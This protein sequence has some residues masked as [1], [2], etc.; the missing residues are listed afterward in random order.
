MPPRHGWV[1]AAGSPTEP[2]RQTG[3]NACGRLFPADQARR[4][5]ASGQPKGHAP[6]TSPPVKNRAEHAG[7][8]A[9][10]VW[11][12]ARVR[13]TRR[14]AAAGRPPPLAEHDPDRTRCPNTS[15]PP[16]QTV[17]TTPPLRTGRL[18]AGRPRPAVG[19]GRQCRWPGRPTGLRPGWHSES[20]RA[21]ECPRL[22]K[23]GWKHGISGTRWIDSKPDGWHPCS[24]G[25]RLIRVIGRSLTACAAVD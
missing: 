6:Q 11:R 21:S 17:R 2:P 12:V 19:S 4:R 18:P 8:G 9:L 16:P 7:A 24:K 1:S 3:W 5:E 23:G 22:G 15:V 10:S 20:K 14:A 25:S 13:E